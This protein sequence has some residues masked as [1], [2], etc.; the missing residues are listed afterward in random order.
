[1]VLFLATPYAVIEPQEI[2]SLNL[3]HSMLV[4]AGRLKIMRQI[5]HTI[6]IIVG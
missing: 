1:M 2:M 3:V 4:S 6:V 5:N